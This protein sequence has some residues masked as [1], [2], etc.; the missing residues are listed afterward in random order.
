MAALKLLPINGAMTV[1][2]DI[3]HNILRGII[4]N[5]TMDTRNESP[6]ERNSDRLQKNP[7]KINLEEDIHD[8]ATDEEKLRPDSAAMDLPEVKDIP[9]QENVHVPPLGELADITASSD[10]E[11]GRGIFDDDQEEGPVNTMQRGSDED[12]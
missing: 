4:N 10:D 1:Q 9:G 6:S 11:E 8:P 5:N 3:R 2:Q 7:G 12:E